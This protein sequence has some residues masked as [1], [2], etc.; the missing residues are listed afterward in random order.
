MV[1][2]YC[3]YT[4]LAADSGL[5]MVSRDRARC[6]LAASEAYV[7]C[8]ANRDGKYPSTLADLVNP[9]LGGTSFLPNKEKDLHDPWGML[10]R[11]AFEVDAKGLVA[12][13]LDRTR[14]ERQG[15]TD[16]LSAEGE[17]V[18]LEW[19]TSPASSETPPHR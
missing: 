1:A 14:S 8:P 3:V 7:I 19:F 10:Y 9:P 5:E 11:Q 16:R 18:I 15:E 17:E 12:S 2:F 13:R 4:V 6:L